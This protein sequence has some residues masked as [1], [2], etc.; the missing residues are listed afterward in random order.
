[1]KKIGRGQSKTVTKSLFGGIFVLTILSVLGGLLLNS[2]DRQIIMIQVICISIGLIVSP[3]IL[4]HYSRRAY[5]YYFLLSISVLLIV[6]TLWEIAFM[7]SGKRITFV[8]GFG[9]LTLVAGFIAFY[10]DQKKRIRKAR[11]LNV[12]RGKF[13]PSMGLWDIQGSY[14][15]EDPEKEKEK[16]NLIIRFG[17][18]LAPFGPP[19]GYFLSRSFAQQG[20]MEVFSVLFQVMAAILTL[21]GASYLGISTELLELERIHNNPITLLS[22]IG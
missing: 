12:I 2:G 5:C 20:Q 10:R 17:K 11:N 13:N 1:M 4:F 18:Y 6:F 9:T 21:G 3:V 7:I 19:I 22:D 15:L 14:H 16:E 8:I